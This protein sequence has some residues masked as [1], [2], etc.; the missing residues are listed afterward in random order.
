[1]VKYLRI[2]SYFRKP[3]LIYDCSI[4]NFLIYEENL[5]FCFISVR[6]GYKIVRGQ[7]SE[8]IKAGM[9]AVILCDIKYRYMPGQNIKK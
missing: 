6:L 9:E 7:R 4:L 5:I 8:M 3:F 1:M 2:S